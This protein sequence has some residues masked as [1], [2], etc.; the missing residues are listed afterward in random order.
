VEAQQTIKTILRA[1]ALPTLPDV[2]HRILAISGD[3][4]SSMRELATVIKQDPALSAN[5]LRLVNSAY[6]GFS[7]KINTIQD[8]SVLLGME[9]VRT[10]ALGTSVVSAIEVEGFDCR[11]FWA[12]SLAVA[13]TT[14]ALARDLA[15]PEADLAFMAGLLHDVGVLLLVISMPDKVAQ[16][17]GSDID[18]NLDDEARDIAAF[19]MDHSQASGHVARHWK[20]SAS[21]TRAVSEHRIQENLPEESMSS[22]GRL[23]LLAEWGLGERY[24]MPFDAPPNDDHAKRV[25]VSMG[26]PMDMV[27]S[28]FDGLDKELGIVEPL[29]S[30][31]GNTS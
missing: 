24:S 30:M 16:A 21:L 6:F 28:V 12:H 14:N 9:G 4:L 31:Q 15:H 22:L 5:L 13:V 10:M 26:Y 25:A 23:V 18:P 7:R 29:I 1:E 20:F 11:R 19:G 17:F 2:I 8:A 27:Q 3:P